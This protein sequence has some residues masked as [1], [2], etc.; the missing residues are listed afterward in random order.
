MTGN[1]VDTARKRIEEL[2][3]LLEHHNYCYY[4]LD[5]PEIGDAAYDLLLRELVD[6]EKRYPQLV[7]P[8]S[9][10]QRVG[11]QPLPFF[12][13]VWHRMPMLSLGN[14]FSPGEL[15]EFDGRIRR[16]LPGE[17]IEYVTELKIDGLAVTVHYSNGRFSLGA[18]R[19]NGEEG[20][21]ISQNLKTIKSLP[22][23]LRGKAEDLAGLE[24]RG[25][26]FLSFE[27]F[28]NLN[29]ERKEM[30]EQ[31]FANPRNAAAGSLRQLNPKVAARRPLDIFFYGLVGAEELGIKTH[32]EA[33]SFLR[34]S[35][36]KTNPEAR[37]CGNI[38][39]V[40]SL[41]TDWEKRKNDLPYPIDGVVVKLNS[42]EQQKRIGSTS[43]VPR[44]AI[45]F[46]FPA[47]E[48]KTKLKSVIVQVGRSGT[49][50]PLA[51]LEPV[52][53]AGTTVARASLHNFDY[54]HSKDIRVGD[55]VIVRKA[56]EIIPEVVEVVISARTGDEKEIELPEFCPACGE[57]A[58][59]LP[60]EVA[61]KC[62]N[63]ACPGKLKEEII[64]F[65]SKG[66]MDIEGLGPA[67]VSQLLE[68]GLINDAADLYYLKKE[69]LIGLERFG[70][71]SADNLLKS[72]EKSKHKP[73]ARLITA[74]GIPLI[75]TKG[76]RILA[77]HYP[78]LQGLMEAQEEELTRIPEIG[79]K[80]AW[81]IV[82]FFSSEENR[83][84]IT[85]LQEAGVN[86]LAEEK[87]PGNKQGIFAGKRLVFT[88]SLTRFT[89][90]EAKEI[91]E[92]TGGSISESVSRKTDYVVVGKDPGSKYRKAVD[93]QIP[94]LTEEEFARLIEE[95]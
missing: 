17:K 87:S 14:A 48:G 18:T 40:I 2:G 38:E 3:R 21:D 75:G 51:L 91:V 55:T 70:E 4:V 84:V 12:N 85:K 86:T 20:E 52:R 11:G 10:T 79:P 89:R 50:T 64:H 62:T 42:F 45:A 93:L 25:E 24:C 6:L 16:L 19:G 35:G 68:T 88:G 39:E 41:C 5:Q 9:P 22:L 34:S 26:A 49:I 7:S 32:W 95:N 83:R 80:M 82:H 1:T 54:I 46:K 27:A 58:T 72:L 60:G 31:L 37:L 78:S 56:G 76:A 33:L 23:K 13:T 63:L 57:E 15:R 67:V 71:K 59:Q 77:E 29:R 66:A 81:S 43:K 73:L 28:E 44:W 61:V 94:V 69:Q 47:E 53:L 8:D 36:L 90:Q 65:V 30:G 74:L 92:G